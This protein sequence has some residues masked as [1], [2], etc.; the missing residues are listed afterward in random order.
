[1]IAL[2]GSERIGALLRKE[3]DEAG[4]PDCFRR[5]S[6]NA[7]IPRFAESGGFFAFR[8]RAGLSTKTVLR[9]FIRGTK[10]K[11]QSMKKI[12]SGV[13]TGLFVLPALLCASDTNDVVVGASFPTNQIVTLPEMIIIG[14]RIPA[15]METTP[16]SV[17]VITAE[18]IAQSQQHLV[19]DVL[20]DVP[21]VEVARTGQP[22][23]VD[24][25]FLR[26]ANSDQTLV[27]VDGIRV[28]SPFNNGFDFSQ[29]A[30][31]NVERIE[32]LRGPQS[33]LYGSE[34]SGG[35]IN[36]ITK[37]GGGTNALSG[38]VQSE[39]GSFNTSISS[40]GFSASKGRLSVGGDG[41][42]ARSDNDRINSDYEQYHL[43]G[44]ARYDFSDRFSATLLATYFNNNDGTPGDI[45]TDDPTARLKTE[46]FL[47]GLTLNADPTD[48]WNVKLKLSHSR[49][50]GDYD[51]P[52]NSN[53]GDEGIFSTTI[54]QRNHVDFQNVF[55]L[56][57]QHTILVGGTFEDASGSLSSQDTLYGP[58]TLATKTIDTRSAYA[59]YDLNPIERVTL[60]AGGR[61]DDSST[62]GA[63]GTY[64][65]GARAT[66]PGTETILRATL[67]TGFRA[68]SISDL[69]YPYFSNPNLKPEESTGWDAGLE[70]PLLQNKLRFGATFFHNYFDN[71]I[72]YVGNPFFAPENVARARTYGVETFATWA[73]LTNLTVRAGYTWLQAENLDTGAELLHR[74]EH[75][76]S[77]NLDWKICP[78]LDA[79]ANA[80]FTGRRADS[81]FNSA[82]FT[83][84][85]V[86]DSSYVK[87]DLALRWQV[88]KHLEVFARAENLLDEH[89]QEAYGYPALGR[90]FYGGLRAQF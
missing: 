17:T 81:Y 72:Q 28:N 63:H 56:S 45:Y 4:P 9:I 55:T 7:F 6:S 25:V 35:V 70:Q 83:T 86:S 53:N 87:L 37:H 29:L 59:Q 38:W 33:T 1:L 8:L 73:V 10:L 84:T 13:F 47:A 26:G 42:Y 50:T 82:T 68:P 64:R 76:G 88:K 52:A 48:W 67:G 20:R 11:G 49:E 27:L 60:T 21:G 43:D 79:D 5:N 14:T 16:N 31:D 30:V 34:A 12:I 39:Y 65:F 46:N 74:P 54:A 62:F 3:K 2:V 22:G 90:G 24:S 44:H 69:Y 18:Q 19:T 36:I 75:S 58:T 23:T 89:Y 85:P 51:Q 71:L 40:A 57:E 15:A 61:V 32:I 41:S 77:L 78:Q 80:L 66:A